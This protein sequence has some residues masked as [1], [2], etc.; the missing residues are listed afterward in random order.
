[1]PP[2][3]LCASQFVVDTGVHTKGWSRQQAR[4]YLASNTA[5]SLHNVRTEIDRYITWPGQALSYKMGE[6]KI[7]QLRQKAEQALGDNF[8]VRD[9][10]QAIL[11]QGSVPMDVLED[12]IELYIK[13]NAK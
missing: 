9:F 10:H 4:D 11:G 2:D 3:R 8:D 12:Q 5:L 7:K 13:N 6:I 1:M